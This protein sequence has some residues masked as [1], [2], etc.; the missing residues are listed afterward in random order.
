M[1]TRDFS[2][3][4]PLARAAAMLT[5]VP[6]GGGYAVA[7]SPRWLLRV[8]GRLRSSP[9]VVR[10]EWLRPGPRPAGLV[11]FFE[12]AASAERAMAAVMAKAADSE[13][14]L[15]VAHP[16]GYSNGVWRAEGNQMAH[17]ERFSRLE[18]ETRPPLVADEP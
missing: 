11:A 18:G 15:H 17:I 12:D 1:R 2:S 4:P 16:K 9:G 3:A 6:P 8:R 5:V 14:H 10:L 13:V 7:A